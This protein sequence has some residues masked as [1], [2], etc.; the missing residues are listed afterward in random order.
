MT[1]YPYDWERE[2]MPRVHGVTRP[3]LVMAVIDACQ[4]FC[5]ETE[6]YSQ[7][8]TAINVAEDDRDYTLSAPSNAAFVRVLNVKYKTDGADNDEFVDLDLLSVDE[9]QR[10]NKGSWKYHEA[11]VPTKYW[12]DESFILYLDF[13]PTEASTG[14]LLVEAAL[15]PSD[16]AAT[17]ADF[18]LTNWRKIIGF[19]AIAYLLS[20]RG[21]TWYDPKAALE[22]EMRFM[23][24][25]G[26]G[27]IKRITGRTRY[28]HR[29]K[30]P[31]FA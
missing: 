28:E 26:K 27:K 17:V 18:F 10:C 19:G 22:Y 3:A 4:R 14:G 9:W 25:M 23:K 30:I 2:I 7:E 20:M 15:K 6:L 11:E 8:L 24:G 29:L 5:E 31:F 1:T 12:V 13:I 21:M 16:A